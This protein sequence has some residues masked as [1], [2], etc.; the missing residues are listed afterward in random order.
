MIIYHVTD[1][2]QVKNYK[3]VKLIQIF[4]INKGFRR[5]FQWYKG[6]IWNEEFGM[7]KSETQKPP[8]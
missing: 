1:P 2:D 7:V 6:C 5:F 4:N 3:K 8:P